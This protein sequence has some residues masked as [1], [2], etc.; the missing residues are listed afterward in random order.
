M[1]E[2]QSR[3]MEVTVENMEKYEKSTAYYFVKRSM[4]LI[5][6]FIGIIAFS[7]MMLMVA[8]AIKLDSRGPV[9]FSQMRVGMNGKPFKMYKFRSM[10]DDAEELLDNLRGKNEMT[11]PMFKIKKDPRITRVGKF[12]RRT[13]IDELPQL[14]NVIKGDMSLV[15]PRPN[16]PHEVIKFTEYQKT[17]LIVKPG[18]T[19]YWQVMG[20]SNIDF[21]QWMKL[22]IKYIEDRNTLLDLK[23]IFKTFGVFFGDDGAA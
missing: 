9:I 1:T 13:S 12:I 18:L 22:D 3:P 2:L 6:S 11:G 7:P 15:G 21:E 20:R 17:K 23:L 14:F 19:C 10:V 16:L 4:D 5:L 8:I